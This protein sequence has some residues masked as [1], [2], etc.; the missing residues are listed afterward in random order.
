MESKYQ[1]GCLITLRNRPWIVMPSDDPELL[2]VKPLGGSDDEITGIFKPLRNPSD[3]YQSYDFSKPTKDDLGDFNSAKLLY[4]ASRLSFR[5]VAGPF[6]C[7]GKLSFRPRS[8]QVVPLVMALRQDVTRLLIAD[9]VGVGKTIEGLL[10]VKELYDRR[11]IGRFAVVCLPHLCEQWQ[12]EIKSK[13]G[14]EAVIIRSGTV[15]ALE[16]KIRNNENIFR[17]FPFQIISIDYIKSSNKRQVFIDHCPELLIVDEAHTCARPKGAN[18]S[19]QQ[20]YKLLKD[21]SAKPDLHLVML[22]ATPHSG[23]QEEFQSLLGLLKPELEQMNLTEASEPDKR[24]VARHFIQ[25]RRADVVKCLDETTNFPERKS[26]DLGYDVSP[27][28]A[29]IFNKILDYARETVKEAGS[30]NRKQRYTYWDVLALLRGIM[31]SPKAGTTMLEKKAAKKQMDF[32]DDDSGENVSPEGIWDKDFACDDNLPAIS[33]QSLN[34]EAKR[35]L[36]YAD[37]MKS[38]AVLEKDNKARYA[39]IKV[40]QWLEQGYNPIIFCRYIHT[41]N[42]LGQIFAE[43]FKEKIPK[44]LTIEVVT[45]EL[46]D[47]LRREKIDALKIT[48]KHLLIATDCLSEGVNLQDG[49]NALLHYDLPWNP[50]R[51]EQREGRIDRFGQTSPLVETA[52]LYGR[53]NPMDGVVFDVLLK[54][55][56]NIR[57]SIG[58]AVPLPE[59]SATVMDAIMKSVLLK[60]HVKVQQEQQLSLFADEEA[61]IQKRRIESALNQ[62][63]ERAKTSR[64]IFAQNTI[65]VD[66]IAKDLAEMDEAIGNVQAVEMFVVQALRHLGVTVEERKKGYRIHTTNIPQRIRHALSEKISID[67]SFISPTPEGYA[68]LGRNHPFV[69]QLSQ[70]IINASLENRPDKAA[71]TAVVRTSGV[72]EKTV[73]MQMRVRNV[74]EAKTSHQQMVAEEMWLMGYQGEIDECRMLDFDTCKSLFFGVQAS[75]NVELGEQ[76]YWFDEEICWTHEEANF[77]RYTDPTAIER[78]NHLV[79][80]HSRFRKLVKDNEY[81]V[82]EPVLPM[83]LLGIYVLLPAIQ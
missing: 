18:D 12:D 57:K 31:S 78:A 71:R 40:K 42:Y 24:Q 3:S 9:D 8:Y 75:E 50:N 63:E 11:E 59:D 54:K 56:R 46:N 68:Y 29:R 17:S 62:A 64:S 77:R 74:I 5:D 52:L 80:A 33:E 39:V 70:Y 28:Y 1:P 53:N 26:E 81:Q 51:L 72:S 43:A 83:D 66:D 25:R 82:V 48:K 73:I 61:E 21:L 32:T 22:T 79:E 2:L 23:H 30:D 65:K 7:L 10:I 49:F 60:P 69:E 14:I 36:E 27:E 55:A 15:T 6:R 13:F 41:A 47:E 45:S 37:E 20:R 19:Q 58:I 67:I 76:S 34:A 44:E 35:L 4:N 38:L 16:R